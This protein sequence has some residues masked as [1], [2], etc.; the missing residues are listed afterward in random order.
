MIESLMLCGIGLLAGCLL[1]LPFIPLVHKRAVRITKRHLV[2]ATPLAINEIRADKDRLRA[3]FAKSVRRLEVSVEEMR[4]KTAS[5]LSEISRQ[6]VE[7]RR[8]RI[9]LDK[10]IAL[11][12]ALRTR[13]QVRKSIVRRIAKLFLYAFIRSERRSKREPFGALQGPRMAHTQHASM[14]SGQT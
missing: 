3:E 5:Q 7:I 8:L 10:R 2:E 11:I 9:E 1:V 4:T 13:D 12:F 14:A 6:N